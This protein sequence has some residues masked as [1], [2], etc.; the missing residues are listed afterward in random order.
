MTLRVAMSSHCDRPLSAHSVATRSRANVG[1]V[2]M[3]D[4]QIKTRQAKVSPV[5]LYLG[6]SFLA[7]LSLSPPVASCAHLSLNVIITMA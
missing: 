5:S 2:R 4:V 1:S 7:A 3:A 6:S